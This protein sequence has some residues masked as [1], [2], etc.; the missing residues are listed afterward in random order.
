MARQ[1]SRHRGPEE[2]RD[3]S[4]HTVL[5][6]AQLRWTGYVIRMPDERR[7][8]KFFHGELKEGKRFQ[9]GQQKTLQRHHEIL[10]ERYVDTTSLG[11]SLHRSGQSG[12]ISLT[13]ERLIMKKR[14]PLKLKLKESTDNT[15]P[16]PMCHQ[17]IP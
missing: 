2:G 15:K 8:R 12:A 16:R 9:C 4:M 17:Q 3:R 10:S 6:L 11:N 1:D 7:L 14:G 13:K 5:K